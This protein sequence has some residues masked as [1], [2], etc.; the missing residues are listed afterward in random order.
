MSINP[1]IIQNIFPV[2]CVPFCVF[3]ELAVTF[4]YQLL[5]PSGHPFPLLLPIFYPQKRLSLF[6]ME[7]NSVG[8]LGDNCRGSGYPFVYSDIV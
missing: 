5:L 6:M 8:E 1:Q 2:L 3:A 7:K 4:F